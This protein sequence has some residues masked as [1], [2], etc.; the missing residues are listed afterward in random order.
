MQ[1]KGKK[2]AET[3]R[4]MKKKNVAAVD[5]RNKET[6]DDLRRK[7]ITKEKELGEERQ[8]VCFTTIC[9]V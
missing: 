7:L 1:L 5:R 2:S 9:F 4:M 3:Q 6:M 8:R